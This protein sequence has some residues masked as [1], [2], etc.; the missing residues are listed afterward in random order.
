M[1]YCPRF[2]LA[3]QVFIVRVTA[4]DINL[5]AYQGLLRLFLK[6]VDEEE[7]ELLSRL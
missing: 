1:S 6:E 7:Q 5:T 2:P 3:L 4:A